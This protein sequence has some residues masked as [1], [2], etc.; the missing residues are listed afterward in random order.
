MRGRWEKD[1]QLFNLI[2]TKLVII[3]QAEPMSPSFIARRAFARDTDQMLPCV[4]LTL[5]G[6]A[7][8]S[9]GW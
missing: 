8:E 4:S 3:F 5:S 9:A 2:M 1:L 7:Y 6:L